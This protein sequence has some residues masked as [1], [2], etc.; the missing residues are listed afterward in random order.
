MNRREFSALL[1]LLVAAPGLAPRAESQAAVS[2]PTAVPSHPP[3]QL[4]T[5]TSGVYPG[6]VVPDP[7]ALHVMHH[8]I[9]GM[10]PE[11]IRL[12]AHGSIL[13]PGAPHEKVGHHKHT[14][15]W[16]LREGKATLMTA[17]V[18]RELKPGD[19]GVCIAGD[20]H[21]I[22][23]ASTTDPVSYFVLT[24]GPPE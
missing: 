8:Y 6:D 13:A 20:E 3:A 21:W 19:M 14:E 16:F 9:L 7:K 4:P 23:N 12:E 1:P 5:L 17:G 2:S 10:L 24:V 11:N 18:E 22:G 15:I